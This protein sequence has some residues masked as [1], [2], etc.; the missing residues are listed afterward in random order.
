[1]KEADWVFGCFDH[2]GPRAILNEL[3]SAYMKPYIDLA[4]DVPEAGI[5]GGHVCVSIRGN[6]CLDCL[7][8][9][10]RKAVRRYVET[11]ESCDGE[12]A[13]YGIDRGALEFKGPS[14]SPIN[15][16][17][18]ALGAVEFMVAITGLRPP[19]RLQVYRGWESKVVV[20]L[21]EPRFGCLVC[22][23]IHGNPEEANVERYLR[24]LHL[25]KRKS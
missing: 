25:L 3:C 22:K 8:L 14:V 12:D 4:S 2:D 10:D 11:Q 1:M 7:G 5:Y 15:G 16:V 9:L 20:S 21:D 19:T 13:I 23:G 17:I 18:A 6:G 24:L